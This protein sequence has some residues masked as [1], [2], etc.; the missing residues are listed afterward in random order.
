MG[1]KIGAVN[2]FGAAHLLQM[3]RDDRAAPHPHHNTHT[4]PP[5]ELSSW[6]RRR[7]P[8]ASSG[9]W[10]LHVRNPSPTLI[11]IQERT[12]IGDTE[13]AGARGR[14]GEGRRWLR[15]CCA[16]AAAA[17]AEAAADGAGGGVR[18]ACCGEASRKGDWRGG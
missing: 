3:I 2:K 12:A 8:R 11:C 4:L 1:W 13:A 5:S 18:G 10:G 9:G 17:A 7:S 6:L 15:C 14:R 16:A